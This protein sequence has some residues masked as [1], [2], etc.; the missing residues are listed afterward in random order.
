M[1]KILRLTGILLI[2]VAVL[3]GCA[4]KVKVPAAGDANFSTCG[5]ENCRVG[6]NFPADS[7][8]SVEGASECKAIFFAGKIF[9]MGN[10][11]SHLWVGEIE[12]E[13]IEFKP[14]NIS[15]A[16]ASDVEFDWE[17]GN[18]TIQWETNLGGTEKVEID[19]EGKIRWVETN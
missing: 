11:F 7:I 9:V 18:L 17:R 6:I 5:F 19:K 16:P 8:L 13:N 15:E 12:D 2:A 10:G 14:I 1:L 3:G 4:G